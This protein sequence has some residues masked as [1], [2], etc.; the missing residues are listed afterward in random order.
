[1]LFTCV[2][3]VYFAFCAFIFW[4]W[5]CHQNRILY[6]KLLG[7]PFFFINFKRSSNFLTINLEHLFQAWK[8]VF[9]TKSLIFEKKQPIL[10][11]LLTQLIRFSRGSSIPKKKKSIKTLVFCVA[12]VYIK[13]KE[14]IAS[15]MLSK[16]HEKLA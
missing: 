1:M 13:L 5:K 11:Y 12:Q 3:F 6:L 15:Y 16:C 7:I 2:L 14:C 10:R 8:S 9:S 4:F